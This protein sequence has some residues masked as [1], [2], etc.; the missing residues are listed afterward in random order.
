MPCPPPH[1]ALVR[2]FLELEHF[3][4]HYKATHSV[5]SVHQVMELEKYSNYFLLKSKWW[6]LV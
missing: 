6:S 4:F 2:G 1:P 5:T 3:K